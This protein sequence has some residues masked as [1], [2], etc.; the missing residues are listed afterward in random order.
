MRLLLLKSLH[1]CIG[2][3]VPAYFCERS[4]P[5]PCF[6]S[7][8]LLNTRQ[9]V[10]L[11]RNGLTYAGHLRYNDAASLKAKYQPSANLIK[12]YDQLNVLEVSNVAVLFMHN[13]A[14]QSNLASYY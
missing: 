1:R 6:S 12:L 8:S 13:A 14:F 10:L 11:L 5:P 4:S 9:R 3:I 7:A 2:I